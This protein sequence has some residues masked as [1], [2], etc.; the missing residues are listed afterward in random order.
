MIMYLRTELSFHT[1]GAYSIVLRS[2]QVIDAVQQSSIEPIMYSSEDL[3]Q[4]PSV[5]ESSFGH[6]L[7]GSSRSSNLHQQMTITATSRL[8]IEL[9]SY[10]V[11]APANNYPIIA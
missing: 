2:K 9:T 5:I 1:V 10:D 3:F 11:F 8:L 4:L 7:H 6:S